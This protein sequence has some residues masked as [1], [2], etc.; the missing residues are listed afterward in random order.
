[1]PRRQSSDQFNYNRSIVVD[2]PSPVPLMQ[3]VTIRSWCYPI[4]VTDDD[5]HDLSRGFF[6]CSPGG[7]QSAIAA[8][9][10]R[11]RTSSPRPQNA[12]LP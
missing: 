4:T 6:G 11:T 10:I 9:A 8:G 1:M 12:K 3:K 7:L 2:Y 5:S